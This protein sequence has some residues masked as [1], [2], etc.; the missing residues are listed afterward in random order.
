MRPAPVLAAPEAGARLCRA[1]GSTVTRGPP[2]NRLGRSSVC[3]PWPPAHAR[4]LLPTLDAPCSQGQE[5]GVSA[6]RALRVVSALCPL[7]LE[8]ACDQGQRPWGPA[9]VG[10]WG[11]PAAPALI[12]RGPPPGWGSR[13]DPPVPPSLCPPRKAK[14]LPLCVRAGPRLG[15][16]WKGL[17]GPP[18]ALRTR[19]RGE[20]GSWA[21]AL[22]TGGGGA[23]SGGIFPSL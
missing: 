5:I 1:S 23:D 18:V 12:L 14:A 4:R 9:S 22:G 6:T 3:G 13:A 15:G 19:R 20:R 11:G 10:G 21:G 16:S 2:G 17:V 8:F 7:C